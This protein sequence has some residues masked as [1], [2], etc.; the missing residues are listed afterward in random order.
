MR[1]PSRVVFAQTISFQYTNPQEHLRAPWIC[2]DSYGGS[3]TTRSTDSGARLRRSS[4]AS[5]TTMRPASG[6]GG[7]VN[8]SSSRLDSLMRA[9]CQSSLTLRSVW[10]NRWQKSRVDSRDDA[11]PRCCGAARAVHLGR[12]LELPS[13]GRRAG[14]PASRAAGSRRAADR[15]LRARRLLEQP[16]LE[17]PVLRRRFQRSPGPVW[18][19]HLY[20]P[21]GGRGPL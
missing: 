3:V 1:P 20:A 2:S 12:V 6:G 16:W 21:G 14:P 5:E 7:A 13:C 18:R 17:G 15:A 8:G 10:R 9:I 4:N 19:P 11:D